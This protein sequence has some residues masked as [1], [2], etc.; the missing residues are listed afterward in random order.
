MIPKHLEGM[1]AAEIVESVSGQLCAPD[2]F[3]YD[4]DYYKYITRLECLLLLAV[5]DALMNANEVNELI[6][7]G[8]YKA[9][10]RAIVFLNI[11][12]PCKE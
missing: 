10:Q 6:Q 8:E 12:L 7:Q 9:Q 2:K 3:V 4:R 11:V 1:S 5:K